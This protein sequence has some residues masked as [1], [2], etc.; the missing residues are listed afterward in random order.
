M[1]YKNVLNDDL[2]KFDTLINIVETLR[3]PGGCPWDIDQTHGSLKRHLLE[4]CYEVLEAIDNDDPAALKE[5]LGDILVQ[6]AF[7]ADIAREHRS[8]TISDL[9]V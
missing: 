9:L 8:F 4:E 7:H 5:E 2:K 1:L 6:I 3:A